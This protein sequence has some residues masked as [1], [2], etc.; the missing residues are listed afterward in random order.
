MARTAYVRTC[1]VMSIVGYILGL[2]DRHC[3]NILFDVT[4][5]ENVHVDF[6]CLFNAGEKFAVPEKVPFRLTH[7]M[8]HAM[9]PLGI[10]GPFRKTCEVTLRVMR[11]QQQTLMSVLRPF[12]YDPLLT[13]KKSAQTDGTERTD[14]DAMNNVQNIEDRLKGHVKIDKKTSSIPL[15]TEG[16][17][18]F[19]I[20]EAT[21]MNN[22][23]PMYPGWSPFM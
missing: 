7:N 17:V 12:I 8:V 16:Q 6:N 19:V 14:S 18:N 20:K 10:E 3:E 21:D 4:N 22:L 15:S 9:G 23:A 2:G 1:G 13:W 11:A 5:G